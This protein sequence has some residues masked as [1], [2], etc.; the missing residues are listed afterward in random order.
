MNLRDE[1]LAV[2]D[3]PSHMWSH[4]L[5]QLSRDSQRLFLA[6]TLLPKPVSVEAL[7][8]AH[9]AQG[10][11]IDESF[12]DSLRLLDDSFVSIDGPPGRQVVNFRNPSL[13]DFANAYIDKN[14]EWLDLLLRGPR[15]REQIVNVFGLAMARL[16]DS[17]KGNSKWA[18]IKKQKN[19]KEGN[20]RYP[21]VKNW[22]DQRAGQLIELIVEL[23]DAPIA[24][25]FSY[26]G[27]TVKVGE[28]LEIMAAYGMPAGAAS[29]ETLK[30]A[31]SATLNPNEYSTD[32]VVEFFR[33]EIYRGFLGAIME[34]DA[35][36][37]ARDN[38]IGKSEDW[39]FPAL[40]KLDVI[41]GVSTWD[42]LD[43]WARDYIAY[44][45]Q[46]A[47]DLSDSDDDDALRRAIDELQGIDYTDDEEFSEDI[48][49]LEARRNE[50]PASPEDYE[51]QSTG[52]G[53]TG[54]V[55]SSRGHDFAP[56]LD[57]MFQSL[58]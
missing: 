30:N 1:L 14:P 39:R 42:S 43:A 45:H 10:V 20:P 57:R 22:V 38:L 21:G 26:G 32:M 37:I 53:A 25:R 4:A 18:H 9:T 33:N 24:T 41:L 54:S 15:F 40:R 23:I 2:L 56:E 16:E 47:A 46:M 6:L 11:T 5:R 35:G 44:G 58:I 8:T 28:L 29:S 50:L 12:L 49:R 51:E 34:S 27:M 13:Q 31:V 19:L 17:A 52:N 48:A 3:D 55:D 36:S 7:R